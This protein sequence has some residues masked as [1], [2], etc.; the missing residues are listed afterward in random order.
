[1]HEVN[2]QPMQPGREGRFTPES[3]NF[4]DQVQE[5]LLSKIFCF[6][7]VSYH[8]QAYR[9]HTSAMRPVE[10]L[11]HRQVAVAGSLDDFRFA[12]L[13]SGDGRDWRRSLLR[14]AFRA[15]TRIRV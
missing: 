12:E 8:A 3:V 7:R 4:A 2:C 5:D 10:L 6:G 13:F 1:Q 11:K 14:D 15:G 9:I